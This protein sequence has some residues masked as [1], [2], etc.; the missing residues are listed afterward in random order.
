MIE[1]LATRKPEAA[2]RLM[3][4]HCSWSDFK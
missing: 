1:T 4:R 3:E 2:A